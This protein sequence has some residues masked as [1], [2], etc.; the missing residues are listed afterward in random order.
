MIIAA[1]IMQDVIKQASSNKEGM[2][3]SNYVIEKTKYLES[4]L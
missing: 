2:K 4:I 1:K 3:W